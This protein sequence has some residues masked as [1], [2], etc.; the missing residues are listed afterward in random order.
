MNA[1]LSYKWFNSLFEH[2][3]YDS[4]NQRIE[5]VRP[6]SGGVIFLPYLNGERT[7][8]LNPNISGSFV[9]LNVNTGREELSSNHHPYFLN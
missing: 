1:G 6:G 7:P 2:T 5:Q 9:G 8:H 3:D 4:M